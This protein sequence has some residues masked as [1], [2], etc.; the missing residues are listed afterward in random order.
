MT[1]CSYILSGMAHCLVGLALSLKQLPFLWKRMILSLTVDSAT[2]VVSATSWKE[3]LTTSKLVID[4]YRH[5]SRQRT[6]SGR[7]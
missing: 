1:S 2:P 6:W 5:Y 3:R 7:M 4:P